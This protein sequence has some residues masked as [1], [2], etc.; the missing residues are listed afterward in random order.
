LKV[1]W[2]GDGKCSVSSKKDIFIL[3]DQQIALRDYLAGLSSSKDAI[4]LSGDVRYGC[5]TH[6]IAAAKRS[7]IKW[8]GFISEPPSPSAR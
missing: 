8:L 7:G 4:H 2:I 1:Q 3:P 5:V 6:V